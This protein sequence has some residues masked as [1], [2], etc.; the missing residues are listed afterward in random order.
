MLVVRQYPRAVGNDG[1]YTGIAAPLE[2]PWRCEGHITQ[3]LPAHETHTWINAL[4]RGHVP[5]GTDHTIGME[6]H[7]C[8]AD[9]HTAARP[10]ERFTRDFDQQHRLPVQIVKIGHKDSLSVVLDR[11]V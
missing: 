6:R 9:M 8:A 3:R 2:T 7:V 5:R 10:G 11:V 4:F 1:G